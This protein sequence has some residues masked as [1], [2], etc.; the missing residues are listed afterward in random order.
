MPPLA[1]NHAHISQGLHQVQTNVQ[2]PV[3]GLLI[4]VASPLTGIMFFKAPFLHCS[5]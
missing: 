2:R 3:N 4:L 5:I 1:P